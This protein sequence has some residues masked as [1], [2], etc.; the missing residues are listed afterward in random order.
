M[1]NKDQRR[2]LHAKP[3]YSKPRQPVTD[4]PAK[5]RGHDALLQKAMDEKK[6]VKIVTVDGEFYLGLITE[7]DK[8]SITLDSS[9][10]ATAGEVRTIFKHAIK[11]FTIAK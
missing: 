2:T 4:T 3:G 10:A 1:D 9:D 5:A 8:F 7:R 6:V 11:L